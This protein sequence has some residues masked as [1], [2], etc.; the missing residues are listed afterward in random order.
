MI[1]CLAG[2]GP[3]AEALRA[4][5]QERGE[6]VRT[7]STSDDD[8]FGKAGGCRAIVYLPAPNL[9]EGRLRPRPAPE[10]MRA[11]LGATNAPGVRFVAF[12]APPGYEDEELLLRRYGVPYVVMRTPPL[13]E[14]LA[15]EP[16]LSEPCS[17]WLPRGRALAVASAPAVAQAL[18]RAIDDDALQGATTDA[19]SE[20]L[21]A[22]EALRRA[23]ARSG[24]AT[25]RT[26]PPVVDSMVRRVG[27][28]F[29]VPEPPIVALHGQLASL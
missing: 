26:V 15:S 1:L 3:L 4:A 6:E 28:L 18:V 29:R 21:D 22:A 14:E 9:L 24:R 12:A 27:R 25:V 16:A 11:V 20:T 23:A 8:L 5:L 10:R 13:L 2:E 7:A 19:P 17:V